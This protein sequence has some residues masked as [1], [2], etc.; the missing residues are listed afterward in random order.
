MNMKKV[1]SHNLGTHFSLSYASRFYDCLFIKHD[2]L[3]LIVLID[4]FSTKVIGWVMDTRICDTLVL[5]TQSTDNNIK[6]I[7]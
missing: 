6:R 7:L 3:D 5:N 1:R 4:D 2:W